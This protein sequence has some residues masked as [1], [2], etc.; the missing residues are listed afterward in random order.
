MNQIDKTIINIKK[1]NSETKVLCLYPGDKW[2]YGDKH[3]NNPSISKYLHDYNK[4][5]I[6]KNKK[7][8][9]DNEKLNR[10]I[11]KF[12]EDSKKNNSLYILYYLIKKDFFSINFNLTDLNIR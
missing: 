8:D 3:E 12:I 7:V 9:F 10:I 5:Q 6:I 1:K 2:Y 4:K 11:E